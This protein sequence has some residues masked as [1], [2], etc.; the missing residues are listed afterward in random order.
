[1]LVDAVEKIAFGTQL[2]GEFPL[3]FLFERLTINVV[4]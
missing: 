3:S 1:M 4:S 2:I